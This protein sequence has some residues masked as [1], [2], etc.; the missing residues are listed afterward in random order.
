MSALLLLLAAQ[1]ATGP[2]PAPGPAHQAVLVVQVPGEG[3]P[4]AARPVDRRDA[5]YSQA[6]L[7]EPGLVFDAEPAAVAALRSQYHLDDDEPFLLSEWLVLGDRPS[8]PMRHLSYLYCSRYVHGIA[9]GE[10]NNCLRDSDGDGRLDAIAVFKT[11]RFP[12][13]GLSFQPIGPIPYHFVQARRAPG[14]GGNANVAGSLGVIWE[15]D[16][17]SGH[18]LFRVRH[19]A[20]TFGSVLRADIDPPVAVDPANLP[21]MIE[22]AGASLR[23]LSWDGRRPTVQVERPFSDR[24]VQIVSSDGVA[25]LIGGHSRGSALEFGDAPLPGEPAPVAPR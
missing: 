11:Y 24:P 14:A 19:S 17:G 10:T 5:F 3:E 23:V 6:L 8:E 21:V 22:I 1:S 13:A 2:A 7:L 9:S 20:L 15:L 4:M 25:A 12:A 16:R 18:L